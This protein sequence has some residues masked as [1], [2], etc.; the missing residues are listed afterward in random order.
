MA[1]IPWAFD[2]PTYSP[3]TTAGLFGLGLGSQVGATIAGGQV[4]AIS[5]GLAVFNHGQIDGSAITEDFGHGPPIAVF[6]LNL[7]TDHRSD[8]QVLLQLRTG[9]DP[10]GGLGRLGGVNAGQANGDPL[11]PF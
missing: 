6:R 3:N 7:E 1:P 8:W 5:E 10:K 11:G 9:S 2:P 4:L